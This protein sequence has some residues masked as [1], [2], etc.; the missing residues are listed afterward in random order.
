M[1]KKIL[2]IDRD[3]LRRSQLRAELAKTGFEI[4]ENEA[5]RAALNQLLFHSISAVV[6]DYGSS[7]EPQSPVSAGR[8]IVKEIVEIDAFV[9]LLLICDRCEKLDH[10]TAAAADVVLR[11]PLA[12]GQVAETLQ[13]ALSETLRERVQRKS[14]Y[15]FAFR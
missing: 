1:S 9:P 3:A 15:I 4:M 8:R 14:G 13:A 10:E 7:L 5:A 2:L 11:R 12:K 6:L